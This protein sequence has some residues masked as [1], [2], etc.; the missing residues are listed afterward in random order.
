M[1]PRT[2]VLKVEGMMCAHCQGRVE[3]ALNALEGVSAQV[4]LDQ[5]TAT[6]TLTQPV[7]R[8]TLVK[9]VTDAGYT[10]TQVEEG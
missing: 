10:V 3:N 5:G 6:V 9:A 8:E 7:D 2:L 1:E 4:D